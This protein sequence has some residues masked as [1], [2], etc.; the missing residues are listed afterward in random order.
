MQPGDV[1]EPLAVPPVPFR[2]TSPYTLEL[3]ERSPWLAVLFGMPLILAGVY[4]A[5]SLTGVLPENI[6]PRPDWEVLVLPLVSLAFLALGGVM[7]FGRRWLTLD[8]SSGS[9]IRQQGLLIPMLNEV[10]SLSEFT[11]VVLA[12]DPGDS[13][14]PV[15]Y[16][17]RL[18]AVSGRDFVIRE[19]LQFAEARKLAEYLS[20]F[21]HL[22]LADTTTDH[23]TVVRPEHAGD[24]L[25]DRLL[26]GEAESERP[27]PPARMLSKVTE[28]SGET[29]IL[30]PGPRFPL[31]GVVGVVVPLVFFL[32]L[33][34][35]FSL[36][37]GMA[38]VPLLIVML[39]LCIPAI[40]FGVNLM[41]DG[42]RRRTTVKASLAGLALEQGGAWRTRTKLV[43]A[44]EILDMDL[45]TF[46][47]VFKSKR[48][49]FP[50]SAY[51]ATATENLLATLWKW[52]PSRGIV[53]KSRQE[54]IT[55]GEG[56][57]VGEL[58][59]LTS[60]LRKALAGA[61]G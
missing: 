47:G 36:H 55:F 11:A 35:V 51:P 21:L 56:L 46:E 7:L 38:A 34:A 60:V 20:R 45:S 23:E 25:R 59:Y 6:T 53:V 14:S 16:P 8:L 39:F 57:P 1:N 44:S 4:L 48:N 31:S 33:V 42:S 9:V 26:R 37:R 58:Q 29:I 24:N 2:R 43:S 40:F 5:L 61:R 49:R 22:P 18:R 41:V 54:A 10:R 30:I 15:R 3:R 52:M 17:V 19:P 27:I 28:S 12:F 50:T 13:E 32:G